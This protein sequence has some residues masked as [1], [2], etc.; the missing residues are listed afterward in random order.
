LQRAK[1]LNFQKKVIRNTHPGLIKFGV[2]SGI[3]DL[4]WFSPF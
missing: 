3:S 1:P 2:E 4:S